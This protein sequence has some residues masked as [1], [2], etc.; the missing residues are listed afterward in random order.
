MSAPRPSDVANVVRGW[1]QRQLGDAANVY[2]QGLVEDDGARPAQDAWC[3]DHRF[4]ISVP[5]IDLVGLIRVNKLGGAH[6][7]AGAIAIRVVR[8]WAVSEIRSTGRMAKR[9]V[10][11]RVAGVV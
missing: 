4:T 2:H 11:V 9:E 10:I 6:L 7:A 3:A 5:S 8:V 1:L